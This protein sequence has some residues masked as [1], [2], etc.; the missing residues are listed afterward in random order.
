ML[1][2]PQRS[3]RRYQGSE[4]AGLRVVFESSAAEAVTAAGLARMAVAAA[5]CFKKARR[6]GFMVLQCGSW[7]DRTGFKFVIKICGGEIEMVNHSFVTD[8]VDF[9]AL[10]GGEEIGR[11]ACRER[12]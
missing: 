7:M 8:D 3:V 9:A 2:W 1:V 10:V 6:V 12:V 4:A 5:A 11:A